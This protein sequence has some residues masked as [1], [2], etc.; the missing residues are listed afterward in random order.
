MSPQSLVIPLFPLAKASATQPRR[1][2]PSPIS[3][4]VGW[5]TTLW[6]SKGR[7]RAKKERSLVPDP[8]HSTPVTLYEE[9]E[10]PLA[11]YATDS[12]GLTSR[13][14]DHGHD[15]LGTPISLSQF[16][17]HDLTQ[18]ELDYVVD[19]LLVYLEEGKA[20]PPDS[21]RE[22]HEYHTPERTGRRLRHGLWCVLS[23]RHSSFDAHLGS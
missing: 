17:G 14:G 12:D 23:L 20:A 7:K 3:H 16:V 8:P 15:A 6:A 5:L 1:K 11:I 13:D 4:L 10:T 2:I 18:E 22:E 9:P 19:A 21:G